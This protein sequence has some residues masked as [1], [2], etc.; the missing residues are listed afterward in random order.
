[1]NTVLIGPRACGKSTIG[2]LLA[3]E[4]KS[5][6]VDLDSRALTQFDSRSIREV[7]AT[8]GEQ[9]WRE[10]EIQELTAVLKSTGQV[11]ALGGGTPAIPRGL[12]LIQEARRRGSAIVIYLTAPPAV[13]KS[14]LQQDTGDRPSL[15]GADPSEEIAQVTSQREPLYLSIAD[16]VVD[17]A[18][19]TPRETADLLVRKLRTTGLCK[20]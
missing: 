1:M 3:H 7:F 5:T 18:S 17:T 14:R 10:A 20:S 6:F 12:Q 16:L 9:A 19:G 2:P 13:L 15:T 11:L 8:H 4:L